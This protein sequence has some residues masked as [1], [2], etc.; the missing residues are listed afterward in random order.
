MEFSRQECWIGLPFPSPGNLPDAGVEPRSPALQADTLPSEPPQGRPLTSVNSLDTWEQD[1]NNRQW[2]QS[3]D[4]ALE[5]CLSA[6]RAPGIP[7]VGSSIWG[8]PCAAI[9]RPPSAG[10]PE[11]PGTLLLGA[12]LRGCGC[13]SCLLPPHRG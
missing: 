13:V 10:A 3:S 7:Q 11:S 2:G 5:K 9:P 12:G 4:W 6:M 1:G 8:A